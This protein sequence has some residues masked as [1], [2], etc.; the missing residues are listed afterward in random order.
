MAMQSPQ[1][2]G[3]GVRC[4]GR[5]LTLPSAAGEP[6]RYICTLGPQC[7]VID[8]AAVDVDAWRAAHPDD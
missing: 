1:T 8:L 6:E 3:E 5:V 2:A 4:N 7:L